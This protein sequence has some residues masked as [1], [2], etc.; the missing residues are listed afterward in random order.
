MALCNGVHNTTLNLRSRS[1]L[2]H[3]ELLYIYNRQTGRL[4]IPKGDL[5][6]YGQIFI[7]N[8]CTFGLF[9]YMAGVRTVRTTKSVLFCYTIPRGLHVSCMCRL[10]IPRSPSCGQSV[11]GW[12]EATVVGEGLNRTTSSA[13]KPAAA[14]GRLPK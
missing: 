2:A 14:G 12:P 6:Q 13:A 4:H 3:F 8:D 11:C 1:P 5:D 9:Q 10:S 7:P